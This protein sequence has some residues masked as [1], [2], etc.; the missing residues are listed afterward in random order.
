MADGPK[1]VMTLKKSGSF[2][3]EKKSLTDVVEQSCIATELPPFSS[4]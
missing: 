4:L 3:D 1:M 2:L